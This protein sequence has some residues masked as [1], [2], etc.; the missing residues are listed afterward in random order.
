MSMYEQP[1]VPRHLDEGKVSQYARESDTLFDF[2]QQARISRNEAIR[3]LKHFGL[4]DEVDTV[5]P[6]DLI[7]E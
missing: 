5:K 2:T 6:G 3:L 7:P 1:T 4:R